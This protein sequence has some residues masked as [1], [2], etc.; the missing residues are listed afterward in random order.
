M[1][2]SSEKRKEYTKQHIQI[3]T[4]ALEGEQNSLIDCS[5]QFSNPTYEADLK[6]YK[7]D[8]SS[9]LFLCIILYRKIILYCY[10]WKNYSIKMGKL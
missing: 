5:I 10:R 2:D 9:F 3:T 1:F 6:H 4:K 7:E 8:G